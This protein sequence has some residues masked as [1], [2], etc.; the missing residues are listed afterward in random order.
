MKNIL[1]QSVD[2]QTNELPILGDLL[3]IY[4][5]LPGAQARANETFKAHSN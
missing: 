3:G 4:G 2:M 1:H 5:A